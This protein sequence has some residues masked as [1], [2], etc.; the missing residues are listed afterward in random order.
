[1]CNS[2]YALIFLSTQSE[3]KG[4]LSTGS[5]SHVLCPL[6]SGT[7]IISS[8][9]YC[10][11]P[12]FLLPFH[13]S[14]LLHAHW[15]GTSFDFSFSRSSPTFNNSFCF[16]SDVHDKFQDDISAVTY[17][18]WQFHIHYLLSTFLHTSYVQGGI[19]DWRCSS[20]PKQASPQ[21]YELSVLLWNQETNKQTRDQVVTQWTPSLLVFIVWCQ[22]PS[23]SAS[24]N[25]LFSLKPANLAW[26][27]CMGQKQNFPDTQVYIC[28]SILGNIPW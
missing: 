5:K 11:V 8:P 20:D 3:S 27:P 4:N 22:L 12:P 19:A 9:S 23:V 7:F 10:Q 2:V 13:T 21:P 25:L 15:T 26:L 28:R 18:S 6:P 16:H 17:S 24:E 14:L 1:M